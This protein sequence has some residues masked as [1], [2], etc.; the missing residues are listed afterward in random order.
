MRAIS[1]QEIQPA[2]PALT[3]VRAEYIQGITGELVAIL[4]AQKLLADRN[5]I[6]HEEVEM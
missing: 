6:V 4:D 1:L 5:I 2:L 3:G